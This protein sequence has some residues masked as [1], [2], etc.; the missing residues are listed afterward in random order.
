[1]ENHQLLKLINL[2][3]SINIEKLMYGI[4]FAAVVVVLLIYIWQIQYAT[5]D[6]PKV[7]IEDLIKE[8]KLRTGDLILMKA[9]N[10]FN[11]VFIVSYFTHIAVVWVN[12]ETDEPM[13]FE[14]N[15]IEHMNLR[16]HHPTT[17]IFLSPAKERIAKYKGRCWLKRLDADFT[18]D[19]PTL[20]CFNHFMK[21]CL[22]NAFYDTKVFKAGFNKFTGAKKCDWA[23][24]CGDLAFCALVKLGIIPMEEY[25][26][27]YWH[28]L[29]Y[30]TK[31]KIHYGRP[32]VE[33][34]DHPFAE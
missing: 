10:N 1:M 33:L 31:N 2:I 29:L 23:T 26:A 4:V 25:D 12:P 13:L 3:P 16:D 14:A 19:G 21:Q 24:N 28:H 20:E 27:G 22:T 6:A 34:V 11:A 5:F 17:G 7:H 32:L 9:A 18:I 30:V 8:K 15:G